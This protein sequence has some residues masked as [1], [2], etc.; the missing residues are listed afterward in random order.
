M[1]AEIHAA[2]FEY[3]FSRY[4]NWD[5]VQAAREGRQAPALNPSVG[6]IAVAT[7]Y[8]HLGLDEEAAL[9]EFQRALEIDP[10]PRAKH[11]NTNSMVI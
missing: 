10:R 9:R 5:L 3:Y 6:H 11:K 8:D 1:L 7:I 4:G 2:R